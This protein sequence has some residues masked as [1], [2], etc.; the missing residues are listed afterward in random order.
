MRRQSAGYSLFELIVT[1]TIVA[2][3]MSL[4]LPSLTGTVARHRQR[5]ELDALFHAIHLARKE[6][7]VRRKVVSVCP[8][9]DLESCEPG[10]NWSSG[11]ILFANHDGDTPPQVDEGEPILGRHRVD[12]TVNIT[13]NRHGFTLRAVFKRATNGTLVVCDREARIEPRAL[14]ISYTG[15]PRVARTTPRGE[16]YACAE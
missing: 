6:S 4:G 11:W 10:R 7:I 16:P 3:V 14:V 9:R 12:E 5:A 13:A 2:I 15:R 1:I 8:S